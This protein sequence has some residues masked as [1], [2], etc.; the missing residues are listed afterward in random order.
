[1]WQRPLAPPPEKQKAMETSEDDHSAA[2]N[3]CTMLVNDKGNG[4]YTVKEHPITPSVG[5][6]KGEQC[7][8][9]DSRAIGRLSIG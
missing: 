4:V 8:V 3:S 9:S 2:R 5:E 6:R 1:M 7:D